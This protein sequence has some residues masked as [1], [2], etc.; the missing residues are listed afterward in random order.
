MSDLLEGLNEQQKEAVLINEGSLLVFA[1]AGSGKTRV[2]TTKIAYA[3]ENNL[4]R[5]Y[6]IL[7]VTFTNKACREMSERVS[8]MVDPEKAKSVFI[9]TFHSFGVWLLRRYG[10]RIGLNPDFT[11]YDDNESAS[12]LAQCFPNEPLKDI[13][14][15]SRQIATYKDKMQR[16][17]KINDR[18][19]RFYDA[20]NAKLAA[21]GNVDFADMITKSIQVLQTCPEAMEYVH[22]RFKM[23][24]VD[25]YQDSNTAQFQLLKLLKGDDTFLCVVGDDDQSIYRFRGAQV[26]N[27]LGFSKVF[28]NTRT[29]VLGRNY[30][31]T[32]AILTVA[33]DVITNNR[34]RAP[35]ELVAE[36][37]GGQKPVL[38]YVNTE[39]DEAQQ[40]VNILKTLPKSAYESCAVLYR[41]NAQSK[42]FEDRFIMNG[43]PY[44]IVGSLKFYDREEVRDAISLISLLA[45]QNDSVAFERMVNKPARG[46]GD[47]TVK[48]ILSMADESLM[49]QGNVISACKSAVS[50]GLLKGKALEGMRSFLSAYDRNR[51]A[52]GRKTNSELVKCILDDFGVMNLY[53]KRDK[54]ESSSDSSRVDNLNQLVNMLSSEDFAEGLSGLHAFLEYVS[55]DPSSLG[56]SEG[57]SETG[58]TLITMHNTKGLEYDRVFC[59]GLEDEIFPSLRDGENQEDLEEERRI[60]YVAFTRARKYLYLFTSASRMVWGRT[61]SETPSRFLSEIKSQHIEETDL[62]NQS[63]NRYSSNTY[64]FK[65][66]AFSQYSSSRQSSYQSKSQTYLKPK[67][68]D[69]DSWE[70]PSQKI[71]SKPAVKLMKKDGSTVSVKAGRPVLFEI[72]ER[73]RNDL[74]G[75]GTITAIKMWGTRETVTVTFD[76]GKMGTYLKEKFDFEKI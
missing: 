58:V 8:Q 71:S 57:S 61:Q 66:N 54:E 63:A 23:I 52:L 74:L 55:L 45:N 18:L 60:C 38:Y 36:K 53:V 46:L 49:E 41:T 2:I 21:T 68:D 73:V 72:G 34:S 1:G 75:S 59:V 32:D 35:K 25:E 14:Q 7:A 9:K 27:I 39:Y 62:R 3:L 67:Y 30:R 47:V 5:P 50:S 76:S 20:Y 43:I 12:L 29:V 65:K 48:T 6:E 24:L 26:E 44:H 64:Q 40:V 56:K 37:A 69:F 4:V 16:P 28:G 15:A 31:C 33:R 19:C 10:E 22:R 11:I 51:E 70:M 13:R 42:P 17:P